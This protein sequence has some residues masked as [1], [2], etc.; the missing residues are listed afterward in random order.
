VAVMGFRTIRNY[1]PPL[2]FVTLL[3]PHLVHYLL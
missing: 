2:I 1:A 3:K